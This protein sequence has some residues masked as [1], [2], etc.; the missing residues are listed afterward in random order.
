[1]VD[2]QTG[3]VDADITVLSDLDAAIQA[4]ETGTVD[5]PVRVEFGNNMTVEA[6]H[7]S[8]LDGLLQRARGLRLIAM[9]AGG[10]TVE[11]PASM[12]KGKPALHPEVKE[13]LDALRRSY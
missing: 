2:P 7:E 11:R 8:E 5:V 4:L 1:M 9:I 13:I 6:T 3:P 10:E 12:R